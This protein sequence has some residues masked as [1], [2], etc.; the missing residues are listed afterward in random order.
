MSCEP[1]GTSWS[2][3]SPASPEHPEDQLSEVASS[4]GHD[5]Q[6]PSLLD[7][8]LRHRSWCAEHG[9]AASN[10][11]L[12]FLG[13]AA[14]GIVITEALYRADGEA[15]EGVLARRRAELVN[16]RVLAEIARRID[17]GRALYLGRGEEATGGRDKSSILADT[18]EAVFGAVYLDG[19]LD[20]TRS[21][22]LGL[23]A[24]LLAQVVEDHRGTDAK[25]RLQ[26]ALARDP[27]GPPVYEVSER[28]PDHQKRFDATVR[29]GDRILG[30]GTGRT[31]KEA[32]Q[33][34]AAE[35][36]ASLGIG[37]LQ[38]RGTAAEESTDA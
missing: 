16:D 9:N 23:F 3:Q 32:E 28:G 14:L 20:A 13:D 36:C 5:F 11:R 27:E 33:A 12:E 22:V 7:L 31:K 8:A 35:A 37:P 10:E 19:G 29:L 34:A 17:L 1:S 18:L 38:P 2:S 26:E 30:A 6:N 21:V 4:I 25:S 15:P 24:D